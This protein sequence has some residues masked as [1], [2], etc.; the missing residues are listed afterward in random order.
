MSR[1]DS[2]AENR[3]VALRDPAATAKD[4]T[5][6]ETRARDAELELER[7]AVIGEDLSTRLA[8]AAQQEEAE[9]KAAAVEAARLDDA[10]AVDKLRA[11]LAE[12]ASAAAVIVRVYEAERASV[13]A[14]AR[15]QAAVSRSVLPGSLAHSHLY[16][17]G[18]D[19]VDASFLG[20]V[21]LPGLPGKPMILGPLP[22][23]L[24]PTHYFQNSQPG[25]YR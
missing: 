13:A 12:Y 16:D 1:R 8:E 2:A 18:V 10:E 17:T 14:L 7:I 22:Q 11:G 19:D 4:I 5:A 23:R 9:A 6:F 15:F 3:K 24:M 21:V 25:P 20:D